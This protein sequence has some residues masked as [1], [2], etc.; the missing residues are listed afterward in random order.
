V[1]LLL[2][3]SKTIKQIWL[4]MEGGIVPS[5][6]LSLRY[7]SCRLVNFGIQ[8]SI[9]PVKLLPSSASSINPLNFPMLEGTTPDS[10]LSLISRFVRLVDRIEMKFGIAP[11]RLLPSNESTIRELHVVRLAK[12]SQPLLSLASSI[13]LSRFRKDNPKS[14]PNMLGI[15]LVNLLG[16]ISKFTRPKPLPRESRIHPSNNLAAKYNDLRLWRA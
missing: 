6:L 9:V 5:K 16:D 3:R 4:L 7:N 13:F 15:L 10:W 1:N 11:H 12:N 14:F 8:S 2:E